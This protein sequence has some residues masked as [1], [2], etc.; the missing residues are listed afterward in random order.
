MQATTQTKAGVKGLLLYVG[1]GLDLTEA[2]D[3]AARMDGL[4]LSGRSAYARGTQLREAGFSGP[5]LLDEASYGD[6]E[7]GAEQLSLDLGIDELSVQRNLGVG[8]LLIPTRKYFEGGDERGLRGAL[9][10]ASTRCEGR[11]PETTAI[12]VVALDASWLTDHHDGLIRCLRAS[13]YPV[14]IVLGDQNDPLAR[15]GAIEALVEVMTEIPATSEDIYM[16][17]ALRAGLKHR[18]QPI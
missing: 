15:K 12:V 13:S 17:G 9:T 1:P 3:L 16:I 8:C 10:G 5:L 7:Q 14:A 2:A 6:E 18:A 11:D 4:V